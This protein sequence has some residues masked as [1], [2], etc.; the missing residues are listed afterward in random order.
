MTNEYILDSIAK[1]PLE[2]ADWELAGHDCRCGEPMNETEIACHQCRR[3]AAQ[4]ARDVVGPALD[5]L[6]WRRVNGFIPSAI[7]DSDT[8]RIGRGP[9]MRGSDGTPSV[10]AGA[11]PAQGGSIYSVVSTVGALA[12]LGVSLGS[13]AP[14]AA[15]FAGMS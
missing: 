11:I 4:L 14:L 5:E 1:H 2:P 3:E 9:T 13:L 15:M 7:V 8:A 10:T 6:M 12:L